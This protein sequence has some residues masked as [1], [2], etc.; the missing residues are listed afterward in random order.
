M[1]RTA[2]AGAQGVRTDRAITA[3]AHT[4][5][6]LTSLDG[7]ASFHADHMPCPARAPPETANYGSPGT[8][9]YREQKSKTA[10]VLKSAPPMLI[11]TNQGCGPGPVPK[12]NSDPPGDCVSSATITH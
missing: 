3:A 10:M 5:R 2:C 12:M 6:M 8:P 11:T 7:T 1:D 9:E 4:Y